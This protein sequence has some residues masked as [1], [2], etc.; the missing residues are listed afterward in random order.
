MLANYTVE[1]SCMLTAKLLKQPTAGRVVVS[2]Q[3][4]LKLLV[5]DIN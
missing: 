2:N 4:N 3:T 1:N 5:K